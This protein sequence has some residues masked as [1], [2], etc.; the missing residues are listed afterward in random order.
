M[1]NKN[2]EIELFENYL[3]AL[4]QHI[5]YQKISFDKKWFL[6]ASE[7]VRLGYHELKIIFC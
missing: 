4:G 3:E 6:H 7:L 2:T 5:I 1:I